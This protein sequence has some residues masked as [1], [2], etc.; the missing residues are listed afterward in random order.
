MKKG[1]R[2]VLFVE[3][4]Q[5]KNLS[6]PRKNPR[7]LRLLKKN[8]KLL[9]KRLYQRRRKLLRERLNQDYHWKEKKNLWGQSRKEKRPLKKKS[10]K[11]KKRSSLLLKLKKKK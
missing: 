11:R 4:K 6:P 9:I 5:Q 1:L 10:Q 3:D 2:P 8:P 7:R